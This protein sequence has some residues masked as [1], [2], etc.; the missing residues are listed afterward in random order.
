LFGGEAR[1]GLS[2][3]GLKAGSQEHKKKTMRRAKGHGDSFR[4]WGEC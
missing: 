4:R 2:G 1:F 3:Q